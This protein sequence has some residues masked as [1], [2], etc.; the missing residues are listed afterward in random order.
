[1]AQSAVKYFA[2]LGILLLGILATQSYAYL[3]SAAIDDVRR[4]HQHQRLLK[5]PSEG[6]R[7]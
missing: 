7:R 3:I 4:Q 6:S 5:A 2:T 1:M